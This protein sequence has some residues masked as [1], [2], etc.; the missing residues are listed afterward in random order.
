MN[1]T[2][3]QRA[4]AD[5]K[6]AWARNTVRDILES[7]K[8]VAFDDEIDRVSFLSHQLLDAAL[9]CPW[10]TT[11]SDEMS[12]F[13]MTLLAVAAIAQLAERKGESV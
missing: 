10:N 3:A 5:Q 9:D 2:P 7:A 12:L 6:N 4:T 11:Q 13:S 8:G 1:V